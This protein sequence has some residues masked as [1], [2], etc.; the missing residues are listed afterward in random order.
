MKKRIREIVGLWIIL[1]SLGLNF[2]CTVET[3]ETMVPQSNVAY[4]NYSFNTGSIMRS[5][6]ASDAENKIDLIGLVFYNET[7]ETYAGHATANA[8]NI[9]G[10]ATG[11]I[12]FTIP[13][14]LSPRKKYKVLALVN[15]VTTYPNNLNFAEYLALPAIKA[16]NYSEMKEQIFV[17]RNERMKTPLPFAGETVFEHQGDGLSSLSVIFSRPLAKFTLRNGAA[18]RKSVV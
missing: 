14:S 18:D 7:D 9:E 11:S 2:S 8:V 3:N 1:S 5:G 10:S 15:G 4:L 16:T 6:N 17:S 12:K 13:E